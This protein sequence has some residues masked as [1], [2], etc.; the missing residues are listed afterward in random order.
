[1]D[2]FDT[3]DT[4]C[5]F[6]ICPEQQRD[7]S[8]E[9]L[10][11]DMAVN[12]VDRAMVVSLRGAYDDPAAGNAETLEVCA[13]RPELLPVA[14][15]GLSNVFEGNLAA[16]LKSDGFV[17]LR[18]FPDDQGWSPQNVLFERLLDECTE[19]GLPV[20]FPLGKKPD[21][22]SGLCKM[23]PEGCRLIL[24]EVYYSVFPEC[25]EVMRRRPDFLLEIGHLC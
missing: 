1:M 25:L 21:L 20:A 11:A 22:A 19:V 17:M 10:L 3:I 7:V 18:L 14:T 8:L 5:V 9:V 4:N 13:G 24:S 12:K 16:R 23:A 2:T 15:A 6:G